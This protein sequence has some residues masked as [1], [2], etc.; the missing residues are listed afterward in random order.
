MAFDGAVLKYRKICLTG[1]RWNRALF[2]WQ[3]NSPTSQTVATA[4]IEQK[5]S[6]LAS[7]QQFAHSAPDFIQIG[8]LSAAL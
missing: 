1:N 7:P 2:A 3:K 4:R 5:K 6:A 8:S